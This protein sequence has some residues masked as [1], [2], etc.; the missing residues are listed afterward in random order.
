MRVIGSF[1]LFE[2]QNG[3]KPGTVN[4]PENCTNDFSVFFLDE[5][6]P[7]DLSLTFCTDAPTF[8]LPSPNQNRVTVGGSAQKHVLLVFVGFH[9][10]AIIVWIL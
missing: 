1:W 7:T 6:G 2:A 8:D 4:V 9:S 3:P 10:V 5:V